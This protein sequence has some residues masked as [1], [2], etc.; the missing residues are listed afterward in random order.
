M[1]IKENTA[2][3]EALLKEGQPEQVI[4]AT[5]GQKIIPDI[6]GIDQ[7]QVCDAWQILSESIKPGGNVLVVGGG[8]IGME[9]ADFLSEKGVK[10]T[11]V[12][13]LKRSPV[14]KITSH[15]YMLH[16]RL[17]EKGCRL[18]FN[19]VLKSVGDGSVEIETEGEKNTLAPIDQVVIAVGL[20]PNDN[21]KATLDSLKIPYT[22]VGDALRPRRIIEAVEEG[23]RA[24]WEL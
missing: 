8:L 24:A 20:K 23:A 19:T 5:G 18:L 2:V 4:L 14:N 6:P 11:L 13:M 21:L 10:V 1:A 22:V 15:G 17:K 12:E 9:A 16:T 3:T 7:P